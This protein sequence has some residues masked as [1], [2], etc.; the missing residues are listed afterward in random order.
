MRPDNICNSAQN[1]SQ[2]LGIVLLINI[3]D[4]L[5]LLLVSLSIANIIDVETERLCEII[6]PIQGQLFCQYQSPAFP[7]Q[8]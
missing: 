4:V 5:P 3:F 7:C 2:A 1:L 6:K 8:I